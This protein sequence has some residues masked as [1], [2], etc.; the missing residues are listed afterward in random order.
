MQHDHNVKSGDK[1]RLVGTLFSCNDDNI[2]MTA[3]EL[4]ARLTVALIVSSFLNSVL[5]RIGR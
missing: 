4:S 3:L 5:A 1:Q 2:V